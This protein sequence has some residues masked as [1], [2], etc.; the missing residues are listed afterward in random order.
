MDGTT[1]D[2]WLEAG[3]LVTSCKVEAAWLTG[4]CPWLLASLT[5]LGWYVA[6]ACPYVVLVGVCPLGALICRVGCMGRPV[7]VDTGASGEVLIGMAT[8][9]GDPASDGMRDRPLGA[10]FGVLVIE[11]TGA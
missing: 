5:G 11:D 3:T 8:E 9:I 1:V 2:E 10:P 4:A 6:G 7:L